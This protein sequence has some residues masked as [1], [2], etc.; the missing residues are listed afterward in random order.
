MVETSTEKNAKGLKEDIAA[1]PPMILDIM[2]IYLLRASANGINTY[3]QLELWKN[4]HPH[5]LNTKQ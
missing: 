1:R 5:T 3:R 2:E 4:C